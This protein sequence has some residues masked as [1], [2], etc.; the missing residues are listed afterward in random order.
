MNATELKNI[1]WHYTRK[2]ND[3]VNNTFCPICEKYGLT[4][5]QTRILMELYRYGPN[6]I[7]GLAE[8]IV[9]TSTNASVMCKKMEKM[10]LL[11]RVRDS[12]DERVVKVYLNDK[13]NEIISEI[14]RITDRKISQII[15]ENQEETLEDIVKGVH[16]L[17]E[18]LYKISLTNEK[19]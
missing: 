18:L 7:G 10:G 3:N 4:I 8:S 13:G 6:T 14:N 11:K 2:I 5:L 17:N 16:K 12:E 19:K 1:I 9:I 15:A